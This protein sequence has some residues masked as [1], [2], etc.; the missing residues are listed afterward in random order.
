MLLQ[1]EEVTAKLLTVNSLQQFKSQNTAL[2]VLYKE[3]EFAMGL[4]SQA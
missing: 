3:K 4:N 1:A 2:F